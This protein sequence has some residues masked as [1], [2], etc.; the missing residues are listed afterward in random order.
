MF[1]SHFFLKIKY[2]CLYKIYLFLLSLQHIK[3]CQRSENFLT[4]LTYDQSCKRI[5]FKIISSNIRF[6]K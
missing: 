4:K 5:D 6:K 2:I 3:V 1:V